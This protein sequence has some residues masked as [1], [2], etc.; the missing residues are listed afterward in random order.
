MVANPLR[1][2]A[3]TISGMGSLVMWDRSGTQAVIAATWPTSESED[4]LE[5]S[6]K[7]AVV[8]RVNYKDWNLEKTRN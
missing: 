8:Y 5:E 3:V 2:H 7:L 6:Q 1:H 4:S